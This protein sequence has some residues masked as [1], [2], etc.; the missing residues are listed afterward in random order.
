MI[1]M[2]SEGEGSKTKKQVSKNTDLS[3]FVEGRVELSNLLDDY[4]RVIHLNELI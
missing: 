4:Y 2:L 3:F 1:R